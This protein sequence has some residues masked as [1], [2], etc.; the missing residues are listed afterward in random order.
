MADLGFTRHIDAIRGGHFLRV[1]N[2]H[3][4]P[5]SSAQVLRRELQRLSEHF[6]SVSLQD[7]DSFFETGRWPGTRPVFMPVFYE[8]YRN[9][10]DVAAPICDEL[11]IT[12]WFPVCTGFIDCPPAQQEFH[13]HAHDIGLVDEENDHGRLAMSWD[14][15]QALS[16]RHVVTPHTASHVGLAD[17]W[18][19]ED[20]EREIFEPKRKMDAVTGQLAPAFSWLRGTACG[21]SPRHDAAIRAAG[22]RY[23]LGNTMIHRIA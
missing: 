23:H 18:N 14:E 16:R 7:L 21:L 13:A 8:G 1:V 15:V 22:Y 19:D 4:P 2:Y 20:F 6:D 9:S 11:G 17:V 10:I 5:A 3:N 12:G